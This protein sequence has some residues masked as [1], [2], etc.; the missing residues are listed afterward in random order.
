[1]R[2]A[3]SGRR[4]TVECSHGPSLGETIPD[5]DEALVGPYLRTVR[6]VPLRIVSEARRENRTDQCKSSRLSIEH[7]LRESA[8][9]AHRSDC[10]GL[11]ALDGA[12]SCAASPVSV[13]VVHFFLLE[14]TIG[15][16]RTSSE[17]I[18]P[19]DRRQTEKR[20]R[21][22]WRFV[23]ILRR[24]TLRYTLVV[25]PRGQFGGPEAPVLEDLSQSRPDSS[26][27]SH[28]RKI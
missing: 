3:T 27:T 4:P 1:V 5:T 25:G 28:T 26:T 17:S 12:R 24:R 6:F 19:E 10:I 22:R 8:S 7:R 18:G 16:E 13:Q 2:R 11:I 21:W 9:T 14:T 15:P 23:V 20:W